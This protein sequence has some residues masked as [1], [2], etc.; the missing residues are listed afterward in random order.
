M[1]APV[2]EPSAPPAPVVPLH[3][4]PGPDTG[5]ATTGPH[6]GVPWSTVLHVAADDT[7][8]GLVRGVC[9]VIPVPAREAARLVEQAIGLGNTPVWCGEQLQ[10]H[11]Y[12]DELTDRGL[13]AT[14]EQAG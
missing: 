1:P 4:Q 7:W 2:A 8:A 5:D 6:A 13:I 3:P 12:A 9:E 14:V 10:A 11:R